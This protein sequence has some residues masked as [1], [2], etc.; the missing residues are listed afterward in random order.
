MKPTGD[1][2]GNADH[3]VRKAAFLKP[4]QSLRC[5]THMIENLVIGIVF[6]TALGYL[7]RLV[8]KQ[9]SVTDSGCAKGCA[10]ACGSTDRTKIE[11]Q[12]QEK[13]KT[14]STAPIKQQF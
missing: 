9:F 6:L 13:N 2:N 4:T 12:M 3:A 5:F 1:K 10:G 8:R 11:A 7:F 14:T